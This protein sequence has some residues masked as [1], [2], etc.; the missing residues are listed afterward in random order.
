MKSRS[1]R[2]SVEVC[3]IRRPSHRSTVANTYILGLSNQGL[4]CAVFF[5]TRMGSTVKLG[6]ISFS[7]PQLGM[8]TRLGLKRLDLR[9]HEREVPGLGFGR[10]LKPLTEQQHETYLDSL[11]F[12]LL[13]DMTCQRLSR[14]VKPLHLSNGIRV[15]GDLAAEVT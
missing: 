1:K 6:L 4:C 13:P 8:M 9:R 14:T 15:F 11:D 5:F 7:C 12:A 10:E 2:Y 3:F